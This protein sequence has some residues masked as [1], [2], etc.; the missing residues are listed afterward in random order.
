MRA[1]VPPP[2][3]VACALTTTLLVRRALVAKAAVGLRSEMVREL[4]GCGCWS[5]VPGRTSAVQ[6][7]DPEALAVGH[8]QDAGPL[9]QRRDLLAGEAEHGRLVG[10]A[11]PDD[12]RP[13]ALSQP[14]QHPTERGT[15][16]GAVLADQLGVGGAQCLQLAA[17][18]LLVGRPPALLP[19]GA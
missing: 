18:G 9:G 10:W 2:G 11:V 17:A 13:L 1:I 3:H 5:M 15:Q 12:Q 7:L 19:L 6:G 16:G 4:A 14:L 8:H